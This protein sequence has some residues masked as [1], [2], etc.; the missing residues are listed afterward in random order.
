MTTITAADFASTA[1]TV[2]T[3]I[4]RSSAHN[5]IVSIVGGRRYGSICMELAD[6][7]EDSVDVGERS[8]YWGQDV[9]GNAWRVHVLDRR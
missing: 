3:A 6:K 1:Q 2:Q 7:C 9:D 8:E 4:Y 5:E